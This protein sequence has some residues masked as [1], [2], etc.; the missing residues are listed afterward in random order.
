MIRSIEVYTSAGS[1]VSLTVREFPN[2]TFFSKVQHYDIG[3]EGS[4]RGNISYTWPDHIVSQHQVAA[5]S[6]TP[7]CQIQ[8]L[9]LPGLADGNFVAYIN[10]S[11][12]ANTAVT[13]TPSLAAFDRSLANKSI[14]EQEHHYLKLRN[15]AIK[16]QQIKDVK[17]MT[18]PVLDGQ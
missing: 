4:S 1:F 5:D 13:L 17:E 7:F 6:A 16:K 11:I 12:A 15:R 18:M 2:S 14:K 10:C 9:V 3:I 8:S